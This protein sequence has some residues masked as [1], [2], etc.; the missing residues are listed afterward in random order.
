M[1][2]PLYKWVP[3]FPESIW[4]GFTDQG[5]DS[6]L[7]IYP[8]LHIIPSALGDF[9]ED[10]RYRHASIAANQNRYFPDLRSHINLS[11][12]HINR[13]LSVMIIPLHSSTKSETNRFHINK[14][15]R[16]PTSA[17]PEYSETGFF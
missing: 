7:R 15:G 1:D 9:E 14:R 5:W 8:K 12:E 6:Y 10:D 11:S 13:E 4:F 2:T 3:P 17:R 16:G